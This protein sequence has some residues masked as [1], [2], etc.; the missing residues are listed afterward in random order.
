MDYGKIDKNTI[1]EITR[2][3]LRHTQMSTKAVSTTQVYMD[4][5][6][7]L[8]HVLSECEFYATK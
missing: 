2:L 5:K 3:G 8:T 6:F 1:K 7:T 4:S